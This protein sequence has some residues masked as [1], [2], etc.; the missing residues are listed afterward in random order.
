[1]SFAFF[2]NYYFS[3]LL[4]MIILLMPNSLGMSFLSLE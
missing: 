2:V 4:G 1:M 3:N